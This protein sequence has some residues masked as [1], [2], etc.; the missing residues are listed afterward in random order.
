EAA[1]SEQAGMIRETTPDAQGNYAGKKR[2]IYR[3]DNGTQ[4]REAV[5][6]WGRHRWPN[7]RVVHEL[8]M[9]RG[10]VRSPWSRSNPTA[11]TPIGYCTKPPCFAR[12]WPSY[13]LPRPIRPKKAPQR[14]R[15]KLL[16]FD[17][18]GKAFLHNQGPQPT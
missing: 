11:T 5:E 18:S 10:A 8:V 2:P 14:H 12:R 15:P 6:A 4:I 1:A 16:R 9:G 13:G 17:T 7:A 3:S